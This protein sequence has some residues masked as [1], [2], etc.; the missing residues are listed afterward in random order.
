MKKIIH[1]NLILFLGAAMT[2]NN[3]CK[4]GKDGEPGKDGSAN[5]F[6]HTYSIPAWSSTSSYYYA[7]LYFAELTSSNINTASVQ[8][9]FGTVSGEWTALPYTEYA[10]VNYWMKFTTTVNNIEIQWWHNT[11]TL[12]SNPVTYY[13]AT[14]QFKVVV[15]PPSALQANSDLDLRN[16]NEVKERFKLKD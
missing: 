5:V 11:V 4:K 8:V 12:G 13:G 1:F 14:S 16:Y 10:S 9:Y 2:L 7:D 15:I 6:S 3:G